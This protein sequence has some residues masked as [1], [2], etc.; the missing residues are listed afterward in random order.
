MMA[1][2]RPPLFSKSIFSF[3]CCLLFVVLLFASCS[4]LFL[5]HLGG[6]GAVTVLSGTASLNA[7]QCR[8]AVAH[9]SAPESIFHR[10]GTRTLPTQHPRLPVG[11]HRRN[12]AYY[13]L[14]RTR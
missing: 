4:L 9:L 8:A 2:T 3:I 11:T 1:G 5:I 13:P 14:R 12:A 6:H 10:N 7:R